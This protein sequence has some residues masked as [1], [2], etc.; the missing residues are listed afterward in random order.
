MISLYLH[1][2]LFEFEPKRTLIVSIFFQLL[3]IC[4][5]NK[6]VLLKQFLFVKFNLHEVF[7]FVNN[8]LFFLVVLLSNFTNEQSIISFATVL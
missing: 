8:V 1:I 2:F 3:L 4:L 6:H 5:H 7:V